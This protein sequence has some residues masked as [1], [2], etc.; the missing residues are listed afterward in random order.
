MK[1]TLIF[2]AI[3]LSIIFAFGSY[4]QFPILKGPYLGQTPPGKIPQIFAPEIVS[5]EH[6]VHSATIF[7]PDG[8]EVYWTVMNDPQPLRIVFMKQ[9]DS[10]WTQPQEVPFTSTSDDANPFFSSSGDSIYFKSYRGG[11]NAIW[12]TSREGNGWS[13]P[14][15]LG[16]PFSSS[17]LGWQASITKE[18][19]I[20]FVRGTANFGS[21]DIY[22]AE[23]INGDYVSAVKLGSPVNSNIDDWQVFIDPDEEYIIFGRYQYPDPSLE[24]GLYV[25]FRNQDGSWGDPVNMGAMINGDHEAYWPYVSPDKKYFF[26][27]SDMNN[28]NWHYDVFWVD[29]KII[30]ELN[31]HKLNDVI[32]YSITAPEGNADIFLMNADGSEKTQLT[33]QAGRLY[34]SAFSPDGSQIAFYNHLTDLTWSLYKMN[35]D[36]GNIQ[37]LTNEQNVLDW[38]PDWSPDGSQIVFAR[39]SS[40]PTW[41]S[42]IWVMNSDG[43]FSHQ[44]GIVEGQ[45]PDWSPDGSKIAYFNYVDGGGDIS[46]MNSDGSNPIQLTDNPSEDWWPKFSPDGSKIIFQSKR[47]GNHEIYV[48]NSDGSNQMRLT[49][50]LT[51]DEDPNWSPDGTKIAFI[52]MRDGHYEIYTMNADGSNQIRIT[53][54]NGHAIDPDWKPI[55][56]PTSVKESEQSFNSVP[57]NF[58]LSQ[59]YPNPFNPATTI[60]YQISTAG[61]VEIKIFN[62]DGQLVRKFSTQHQQAG[63][64]RVT[65]DAKSGAGKTVASGLYIYHLKFGNNISSKKMILIK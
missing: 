59:N 16:A 46:V 15:N 2:I 25:S 6:P 1:L 34:G 60:E 14:V 35:A 57:Q 44:L 65:W 22:R 42:E 54:T 63:I 50:N 58:Q 40:A 48:M 21:N 12:V 52:S 3:L 49:N 13:N 51:D 55:T 28:G 27:V 30:E 29:A 36:G 38:S 11:T 39:S 62:I 56:D 9:V 26:F 45:G 24:N 8:N 53:D 33:D 7:S 10:V 23:L 4:A 41:R 5:Q 47:D 32:A 20:Y 19:T 61:E 64:Y 43:S 17:G 18:R 31:P 37:Q